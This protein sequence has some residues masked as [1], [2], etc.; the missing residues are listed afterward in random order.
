MTDTAI[1]KPRPPKAAVKV[2]KPKPF[3]MASRTVTITT[4]GWVD[5]QPVS[6]RGQ[7]MKMIF[8]LANEFGWLV[9]VEGQH[10]AE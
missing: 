2:D 9:Q 1:A 6:K 8:S 5:S 7:I 3:G 10:W 4:G